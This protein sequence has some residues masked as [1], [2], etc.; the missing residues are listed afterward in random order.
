MQVRR[1]AQVIGAADVRTEVGGFQRVRRGETY[2]AVDVLK[3]G[4]DPESREEARAERNDVQSG[5]ADFV[6][7]VPAEVGRQDVDPVAEEA[8]AEIA[9]E[10]VIPRVIESVSDALVADIRPA[11]ER[12]QLGSAALAEGRRAVEPEVSGTV[13]A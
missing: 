13:A 1:D 10:P 3:P 7:G 5:H 12:N 4:I 9:H 11:P 2:S 6:R 8:E